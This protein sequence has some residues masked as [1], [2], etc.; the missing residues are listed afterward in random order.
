MNYYPHS[1]TTQIATGLVI[2][3]VVVAI[4]AGGWLIVRSEAF[5]ETDTSLQIYESDDFSIHLPENLIKASD[6]LEA[7]ER[8]LEYQS[9]DW[10]HQFL[11]ISIPFNGPLTSQHIEREYPFNVIDDFGLLTVDGEPAFT[12]L[13]DN[14]DSGGTFE[15]WFV[16]DSRLY[17][18]LTS[19]PLEDWLVNILR[20]WQFH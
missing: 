17:K 2:S 19:G 8:D 5:V 7:G 12:F 16:H 6:S 3:A 10:S 4:T 9:A 11:L 1:L 18:V 20:T 14:N 13:N 15:V